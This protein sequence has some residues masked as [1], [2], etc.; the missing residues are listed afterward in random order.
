MA[1]LIAERDEV[2]SLPHLLTLTV[3][4]SPLNLRWLLLWKACKRY[5]LQCDVV[6]DLGRK[7]KLLEEVERERDDL[8]MQ[9]KTKNLEISELQSHLMASEASPSKASA[10]PVVEE[11][12]ASHMQGQYIVALS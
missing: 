7:A 8:V 6:E 5:V 9:L 11:S 12:L 2:P 3:D 4:P 10:S 1:S